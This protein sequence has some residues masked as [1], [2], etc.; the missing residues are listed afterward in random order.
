MNNIIHSI[1][2][3][4]AITDDVIND[5]IDQFL[6]EGGSINAIGYNMD[7]DEN[8]NDEYPQYGI[9]HAAAA[10]D[11]INV[12]LHLL[13]KPDIDV[14]LV[15][16]QKTPLLSALTME[17]KI[18]SEN[19]FTIISALI[20]GG[21]DV[22]YQSSFNDGATEY[23]MSWSSDISYNIHKHLIKSGITI[24]EKSILDS[25]NEYMDDE[26]AD[27]VI[28]MKTALLLLTFAERNN[29]D[30]D[31]LFQ[32]QEDEINQKNVDMKCAIS[33]LQLNQNIPN[34]IQT[35][36]IKTSFLEI[37]P[38]MTAIRNEIKQE[39][40]PKTTIKSSSNSI[41]PLQSED[42]KRMKSG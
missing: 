1:L 41:V 34:M 16:E 27:D 33:M 3:K 19:T 39:Y 10:S 4:F 38:E 14:N 21:A 31:P 36:A 18:I 28:F 17:H 7:D 23:L 2:E 24:N 29:Y 6:E 5:K 26:F 37:Q 35:H 9:L 12:V 20:D 22:N 13:Q 25:L 11:R 42:N 40:H 32:E 30:A 8:P 15:A